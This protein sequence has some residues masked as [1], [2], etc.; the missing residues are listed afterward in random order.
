M[1]VLDR[2]RNTTVAESSDT[3][4]DL[5][6]RLNAAEGTNEIL[7]ESLVDAQLALED[8]GWRALTMTTATEFTNDGLHRA[9]EIGRAM[10]VTNPLIRRGVNLRIAYIWGS[11]CQ[12]TAI[13]DDA[14]LTD[15]VN[16]V[17]QDFLDDE[18]NRSAFTGE[19][20]Q[21]ELER[22]LASDGNV[23]LALP[24]A[25][26]TGR[27]QV[28][29][30]GFSE[31]TDVIC[32]PEDRDDPWFYKRT[33]ATTSVA[34]TGAKAST[35]TAYYPALGFRPR[36][37]PKKVNGV[38]VRWDTPVL[39]VS[40]NRLDG[41]SFGLGDVYTAMP[42]ARAYSEF[43][44]DWAGLVRALSKFAWRV[45]SGK[46]SQASRA[47]S[48]IR[49]AL[50]D[51]EAG[52]TAAT[53]GSTLE[54]IPKSG[55]TIDSES[56]RPLAA[57]VAASL[58]VP[59]TMLLGD[60]GTTGARA[61]AE[62]L[63]QPMRLAMGARRRR[64]SEAY[65]RIGGYVIGESIRAPRGALRGT[66]RIDEHGRETIT[67]AGDV[68]ATVQTDWPSLDDTDV[69]ATIKAIVEAD[70]T[71]KLPPLTIARL[72]LSALDVDDADDVIDQLTDDNGEWIDP[73]MA[74][75]AQDALDAVRNR[76]QLD[77]PPAA[78]VDPPADDA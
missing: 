37:R 18:G 8:R 26:L 51:L 63:D 72:L 57:V 46:A 27:V 58:D 13:C 47:A 56:G 45:S 60:P 2:F 7:V 62:T 74:S 70:G 9:A 35:N 41:W 25:P 15:D 55:A 20:A 50:P 52:A 6:T 44:R 28:R 38:E 42:L 33:W 32:N 39:H 24:T 34:A 73:D 76:T 17:V 61:T 49:E 1:G 5:L 10:V 54:A 68:K 36:Q 64:W 67:L 65:R 59:V 29:S 21:E 78:P 71:R 11:G 69:P 19:Q 66:V 40:V 12:I 3:S 4:A 30:I 53:A 23:F 75:A 22:A 31:I 77:Q 48:R 43:L 14:D 16:T